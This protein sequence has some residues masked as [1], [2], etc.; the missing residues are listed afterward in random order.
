VDQ[1]GNIAQGN[2]AAVTLFTAGKPIKISK[3]RLQ[4]AIIN[5]NSG[6]AGTQ[7][8][9]FAIVVVPNGYTANALTVSA[10]AELYEPTEN[11]M[12]TGTISGLA[13]TDVWVPISKRLKQGDTLV[14]VFANTSTAATNVNIQ[15]M[16]S[17]TQI[18]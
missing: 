8:V 17:Y 4:A 13:F 11:V 5:I 15:Y 7:G 6:G 18:E 10:A 12:C 9:M 2:Q 1:T 16:W 14:A 3:M